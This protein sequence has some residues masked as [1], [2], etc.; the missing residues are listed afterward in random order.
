MG[1]GSFW[2]HTHEH[3]MFKG[4]AEISV[5]KILIILKIT[6][7]NVWARSC[8]WEEWRKLPS[9]RNSVFSSL[10]S[11]LQCTGLTSYNDFPLT[12]ALQS[13]ANDAR[14]LCDAHSSSL[15]AKRIVLSCANHSRELPFAFPP[16]LSSRITRA[17]IRRLKHHLYAGR[18]SSTQGTE[19]GQKIWVI[20]ENLPCG[21]LLLTRTRE[22]LVVLNDRIPTGIITQR[23]LPVFSIN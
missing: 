20:Q 12:L 4:R 1:G 13:P 16:R 11:L 10:L 8:A 19:G 15:K 14:E 23:M 7:M 18:I 2:P 5:H 22:D 17:T 21:V 3:V 9:P 6:A